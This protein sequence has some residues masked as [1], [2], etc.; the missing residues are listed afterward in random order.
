MPEAGGERSSPLVLA[1]DQF[2]AAKANLR[3]TVKWLTTTFAALAAVVLAGTSLTGISTLSG[4]RLVVAL[5]GGAVGLISI[6]LAIATALRLL[7]SE[8][9]FLT[10]L[11]DDKEIKQLLDARAGDILPPE[12][13]TL[14]E[15]LLM[16]RQAIAKIA[17]SKQDPTNDDYKRASEFFASLEP[18]VSRLV[19]LAHFEV[20]RRNLKRAG[21]PLFL[22]AIGTLVGLGVF[23]VFTGSGK[24][25][26]VD[27]GMARTTLQL[28]SGKRLSDLGKEFAD[29][30]GGDA[31]PL[32]A[33]LIGEPRPGWMAFR[34]VT[35]DTCSGL[36]ISVPAHVIAA[37]TF[38]PAR[39][40]G[41]AP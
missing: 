8:S 39:S 17:E 1:F 24:K 33:Q 29:A 4:W 11:E 14:D 25:R 37:S 21:K 22:F 13:A 35:P 9:F 20:L 38:P 3:D 18:S 12:F 23:A 7:I 2:A 19:N 26:E 15:F 6:F 30:C 27:A 28:V 32:E 31:V 40:G 16:R 5:A 41:K 34:L 10:Q 36:L